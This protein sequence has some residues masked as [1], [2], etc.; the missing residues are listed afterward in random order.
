MFPLQAQNLTL[1]ALRGPRVVS[2]S[3]VG[4]MLYRLLRTVFIH[5]IL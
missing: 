5:K 2:P 4:K 1:A 3:L